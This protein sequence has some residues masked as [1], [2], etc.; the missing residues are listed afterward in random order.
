MKISIIFLILILVVILII[1][2]CQ[3]S[4][5]GFETGPA[6]STHVIIPPSVIS[7]SPSP[8]A[9]PPPSPPVISAPKVEISDVYCSYGDIHSFPFHFT[10]NNREDKSLELNYTWSLNESMGDHPWYKGQGKITLS[11]LGSQIIEVIVNKKDALDPRDYIMHVDV[12]EG[13]IN[14]ANFRDQKSIEDWDYS[15]SPP[16]FRSVKPPDKFPIFDTLVQKDAQ[17]F[18]M[19]ITDVRFLPPERTARLDLNIMALCLGKTGAYPFLC[20]ELT[21]ATSDAPDNLRF[22]DADADGTFSTGDYITVDE[23]AKGKVIIFISRED[24]FIQTNLYQDTLLEEDLE[25]IRI[26][27][28]DYHIQDDL[29][30]DLEIEV[31]ADNWNN[32]RGSSIVLYQTSKYGGH[33]LHYT[34]TSKANTRL[35]WAKWDQVPTR[36]NNSGPGYLTF[37]LSDGVNEVFYVVCEIP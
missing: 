11:A 19:T 14:V 2:G 37:T 20:S 27:R 26:N 13:N 17:G 5:T 22:Y 23:Q 16:V 1:S 36:N 10:L 32:F 31:E 4:K 8:P 30:M 3:A 34:L 24:P 12:F 35:W 7:N 6:S 25:A 9:I 29:S 33:S 18:R 15:S 28:V 21:S